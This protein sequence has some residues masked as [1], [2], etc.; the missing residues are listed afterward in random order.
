[1]ESEDGF[2]VDSQNVSLERKNRGKRVLYLG[3]DF[4]INFCDFEEETGR[5][6]NDVIVLD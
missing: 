4:V 1:M 2:G 5:V 3:I 6:D